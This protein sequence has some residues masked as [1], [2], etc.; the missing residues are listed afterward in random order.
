MSSAE[1]LFSVG[2]LMILPCWVLL[3]FLPHARVT[4]FL[5]DHARVSPALILA[6]LYGVAVVPALI[7]HP[8]AFSA[9]ARPTLAGVRE[10]LGSEQGLA[11]GWIH[12]LCFDLLVG[13]SVWRSARQRGRSFLWVSPILL[14]VLM[15]G[16][17][18]WLLDRLVS[19]VS[20]AVLRSKPGPK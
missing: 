18:G 11:A 2:N 16:P 13:I 3:I 1:F 19:G 12:Y 7:A 15:L 9:L 14:L 4:V 5:F 6:A 10:L 8:E 20:S 17:L